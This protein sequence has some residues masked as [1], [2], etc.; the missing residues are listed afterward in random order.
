MIKPLNKI[1]LEGTYF[2]IIKAIYEKL[3]A[4]IILNGKKTESFTLNTGTKQGYPVSSLLF[5]IVL[6]VLATTIRQQKEMK[7]IQL[8]KEKTKFLLSAYDMILYM[9]SP[10]D[11]TKK[12]TRTDE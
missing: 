8:S 2:N 6:E 1:G 3:Q 9:E 12:T 7:G 10:K 5:N 4:K 11:S